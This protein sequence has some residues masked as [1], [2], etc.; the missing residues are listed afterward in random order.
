MCAAVR[1]TFRTLFTLIEGFLKSIL[2]SS[3][4]TK[5][6]KSNIELKKKVVVRTNRYHGNK[7]IAIVGS[8]VAE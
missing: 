2:V 1:S 6:F 7:I 5:Q 4:F 8:S 3:L